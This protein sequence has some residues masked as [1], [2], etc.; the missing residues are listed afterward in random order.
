MKYVIKTSTCTNYRL[1]WI[2]RADVQEF[3]IRALNDS[4]VS[5]AWYNESIQH[6][7][8]RAPPSASRG[9]RGASRV[10]TYIYIATHVVEGLNVT[11][12]VRISLL[13]HLLCI[14]ILCTQSRLAERYLNEYDKSNNQ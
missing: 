4:R 2:E 3:E 12:R 7:P 14:N 11:V 6:V 10:P 8:L 5:R 1:K 9:G 13:V